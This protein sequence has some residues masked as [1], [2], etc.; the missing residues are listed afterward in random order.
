VDVATDLMPPL[1]LEVPE[2]E[3]GLED[4]VCGDGDEIGCVKGSKALAGYL[5]V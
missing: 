2:E 4:M 3:V 5:V 1:G